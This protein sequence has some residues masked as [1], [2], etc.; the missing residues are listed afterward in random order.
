MH[1]DEITLRPNVLEIGRLDTHFFELFAGVWKVGGEGGWNGWV[2]R[3]L[4]EV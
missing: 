2:E 4:V 3:M 1:S